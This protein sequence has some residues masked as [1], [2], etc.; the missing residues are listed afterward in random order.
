[1]ETLQ[2]LVKNLPHAPGVY[3]FHGA[4]DEILYV[5]KAKDLKKR[6]SQYFARD[7]AIGPKTKQLVS[8]IVRIETREVVSEFDALMLEAKLIHSIV[9]KY[10]VLAKDD[11][12]PIYIMI[13]QEELPHIKIIRKPKPSA[14]PSTLNPSPY[15]YGPFQSSRLLRSLLREVRTIVPYCTSKERRGKACF[16][17][18]IGLCNPCP[19]LIVM[20]PAGVARQTLVRAYRANIRKIRDLF[21]GKSLELL[22]EFEKEMKEASAKEQFEVAAHRKATADRLRHLLER[23]YDPHV[24]MQ[25]DIAV[26]DIYTNELEEL[27]SILKP[28]YPNI[29]PLTRIECVD[30]S[31]LQGTNAT[32]SLVVLAGGKPDT[33]SYRRFKMKTKGPNDVAMIREVITRRFKHPEWPMPDLLLIDGGKPQVGS[34]KETLAEIGITVPFAGLAKRYE[35]IVITRGDSQWK[36]I[37]V[38][39]SNPALHVLQRIRDEAHRFAITYHRLLRKKASKV[40]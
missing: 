24:Y 12:S 28:Y 21:S 26:E 29:T 23:H 2:T 25:T 36:I 6:V 11:K 33:G 20:M 3:L 19:A 7:D 40:A 22:R 9:P 34:A 5:G 1:M 32:A 14:K 18:H 10:N 31:N 17:T 39:Y 13:T 8:Q 37:T 15:V 16:Y 38:P 27:R 35:E 30:I 4:N